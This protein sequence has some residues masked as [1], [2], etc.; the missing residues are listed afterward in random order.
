[1]ANLAFVGKEYKWFV[2]QVPPNQLA[3]KKEQG[4]W[5]D[6]VKVRI[7]GYHPQGPEVTDENLPWAIIAK[8]TSQGSYNYGSTG[9]AGGEWVT[10]YFLDEA[11]QI[12]VITH[13]LGSSQIGNKIGLS[14]AQEAKTTNFKNVTRY[15]YGIAAADHQQK[16]GS[17]PTAPAKPTKEEVDKA[18]PENTAPP[19]EK[20]IT[21]SGQ[22]RVADEAK[23]SETKVAQSPPPTSPPTSSQSSR[24]GSPNNPITN[25]GDLNVAISVKSDGT[26][27]R[28][29]VQPTAAQISDA[30]KNG[31]RF[32]PFSDGRPGGSFK[33]SNLE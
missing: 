27:I 8:P 15:N 17:K 12:P 2:G 31:Y 26:S 5:G 6:R 22:Q 21:E 20:P 11:C 13:V 9:L 16:G 10:G 3:N 32:A 30:G 28:T 19:I 7:Q 29:N 24:Y 1:M 25:S 23:A 14:K 18:V 33:N 4:A